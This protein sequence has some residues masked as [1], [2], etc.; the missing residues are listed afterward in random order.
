MAQDIYQHAQNK[1]QVT[2]DENLD[3]RDDADDDGMM[4]EE[5]YTAM[6]PAFD[7]YDTLRALEDP[8]PTEAQAELAP[9]EAYEAMKF[10]AP[11]SEEEAYILETTPFLKD[12]P[13]GRGKE[14]RFVDDADHFEWLVQRMNDKARAM[15]EVL[16]DEMYGDGE[17]EGDLSG[18]SEEELM[19]RAGAESGWGLRSIVKKAASGVRKAGGVVR[20]GAGVALRPITSIVRK[21]VPGR[22]KQKAA[23]VKNLNTKLVTGRTNFLMMEDAKRKVFKPRSAYAGT[24]KMWAKNR[25]QKGGL[26]TSFTAGGSQIAADILGEDGMGS[27][28]NPFSWFSKQAQY[29]LVN[30][31][32]E[33]LASMNQTEYDAYK[34]TQAAQAMQ[35]QEGPPP[36][37]AMP[38]EAPSMEEPTPDMPP[39]E[40][41][42]GDW[43]SLAQTVA[44]RVQ[45]ARK[46]GEG[47]LTPGDSVDDDESGDEALQ[48]MLSKTFAQSRKAGEGVFMPT[49]DSDGDGIFVDGSG[50]IVREDELMQGAF[51][52]E[53]LYGAADERAVEQSGDADVGRGFQRYKLMNGGWGDEVTPRRTWRDLPVINMPRSRSRASGMAVAMPPPRK[54]YSNASVRGQAPTP[55]PAGPAATTEQ[56]LR[57]LIKK[58]LASGAV[59]KALV[60]KW[61]SVKAGSEGGPQ[62]RAAYDHM[63]GMIAK[64]GAI[65]SKD[66]PFGG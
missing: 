18:L 37:G 35:Q 43:N 28:W 62:R 20:K 21:F 7:E 38:D 31:Q 26:P 30:A 40:E 42:A 47:V 13:H 55:T 58:Q 48:K 9:Q 12:D 22:D 1:F 23:L 53:S 6:T 60:S 14:V 34:G 15:D 29:V 65:I 5:G 56:N 39:D 33:M 36:E 49:D 63:K 16:E 66:K 52:G 10:M 3:G 25:I 64:R 45:S 11:L 32:G 41:T 51:V 57:N 44:N 50:N 24:A 46:V 8:S 61:A 54:K 2:T 19:D 17:L 59:S 27:W 4:T